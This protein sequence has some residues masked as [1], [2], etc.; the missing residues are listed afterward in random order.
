MVFSLSEAS[1]NC[2]F[3]WCW[4]CFRVAQFFKKE[5]MF[6]V[7]NFKIWQC[8]IQTKGEEEGFTIC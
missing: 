7:I 5:E 8:K 4:Q 3:G 6:I 2:L 1:L